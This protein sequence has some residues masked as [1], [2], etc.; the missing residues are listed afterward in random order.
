MAISEEENTKRI[1][2]DLPVDL[3]DVVDELKKEWG[4]RSRGPVLERLLEELTVKDKFIE[5]SIELQRDTH[6]NIE[7]NSNSD[8]IE[9]R[10]SES[11]A[12]V[13]IGDR[14]IEPEELDN[15]S[16][17]ETNKQNYNKP[18]IDLPGF[19][20]K[21]TKRIKKSLNSRIRVD[22][23]S[24]NLLKS[25]RDEDI[26]LALEATK[27]HWKELYGS[28]PGENVLEAA[29]IWLARDI[30]PHLEGTEGI[31]FTWSASCLLMR[32]LVPTWE[33]ENPR[34]ETVL[35]TAGILEDPFSS[36]TLKDRIPTLTR[37][38]VNRFK[39]SR[40]VTSFQTLEST[41]TV[42]GAL[43]LLGLSTQPGFA[44]KL[45]NIRDAYKDK[46]MQTHP[47]AGGSTESMR[48]INEA[49]Q[50]LKELYKK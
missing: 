27:S 23:D 21:G 33:K 46:A 3:V 40:N 31:T 49:Y 25:V 35:V 36:R 13:L 48:K 37:R 1:S 6:I 8:T 14:C 39:R 12:I 30:W 28:Q 41:M 45:E 18:G 42:H 26:K 16:Q 9:E 22:P 24:A 5:S 50:L 38:F 19:V 29:M 4:F 43:K 10:Y 15:I 2:V 47:D 34:Y 17:K 11:K 44:L 32:N 7:S 20:Q